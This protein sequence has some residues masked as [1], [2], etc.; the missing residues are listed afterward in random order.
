[1]EKD[2]ARTS[3]SIAAKKL[4]SGRKHFKNGEL[5]ADWCS[6]LNERRGA[7]IRT[8][9]HQHGNGKM[10]SRNELIGHRR[11][12]PKRPSLFELDLH[13][14]DA[15]M[16]GCVEALRK[17]S[18]HRSKADTESIVKV[19][20]RLPALGELSPE[21]VFCPFRRRCVSS[22]LSCCDLDSSQPLRCRRHAPRCP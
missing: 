19:L 9:S 7:E 22:S 18:T 2:F 17:D 4:L 11:G 5:H 3:V 10:G 8:T 21:R 16:C 12:A 15:M 13:E 20:L 14:R 6:L 1:M